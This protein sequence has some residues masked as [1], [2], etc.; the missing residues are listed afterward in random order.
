MPN[1]SQVMTDTQKFQWGPFN[2]FDAKGAD[3][4]PAQ[5]VTASTGDPNILS[6][7]DNGDGTFAFVAGNPGQTQAIVTDSNGKTGAVDV[8]VTPGAE[9]SIS[10]P[11]GAPVEQ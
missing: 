5:G 6:A 11:V 2:A 1:L 9:A 7:V 8:T 10:G 4:G 3:L